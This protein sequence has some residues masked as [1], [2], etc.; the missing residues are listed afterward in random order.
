MKSIFDPKDVQDTIARINALKPD[1]RPQWGKMS[2][3]QML[4]HCNAIYEVAHENIHPRPGFIKKFLLKIFVKPMVVGPRP[5]P[6]NS[7]TA[8]EFLIKDKREFDKEKDRLIAY[9][10]KTEELGSEYFN[11]RDYPNFGK[12]K[13]N[14][15]NV[16]FYKHLD[17]H[18]TQFGV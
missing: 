9:L 11:N 14:E 17:H 7:R 10:K 8:P 13:T 1:S 3:D 12:L 5:Y 18:L 2:V 15:W 6:R 4:A 16:L